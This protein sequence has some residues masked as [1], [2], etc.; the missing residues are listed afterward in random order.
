MGLNFS[1][2]SSSIAV[3]GPNGAGK[4]TLFNLLSTSLTGFD[5]AFSVGSWSSG[6]AAAI[7]E[8]RRMLGYVPQGLRIFGGYTSLEF[9]RYVAWLRKMPPSSVETCCHEALEAVALSDRVSS[10][11]KSLS[12]GMK[13]RLALAS[14]LVS[15]P[16]LLLLDEPTVG[17]DPLQR[18]EFRTALRVSMEL[19]TVVL[20]THLVDDVAAVAQD[21]LVLN[22]GRQ[23]FAGP[24]AHFVGGV[25][26]SLTGPQVE[27]AYL[28]VVR[29]GA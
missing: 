12:G 20:A 22:E 7:D 27:D 26:G 2:N 14:A 1:F 11:V 9:L 5:G 6:D 4:S 17:L 24:I 16:R 13:Q 23:V 19:A 18:N 21:V 10:P 3:L 25:A 15:R 8:H 29:N 28:R